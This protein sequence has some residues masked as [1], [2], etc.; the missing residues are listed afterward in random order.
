M[1]RHSRWAATLRRHTHYHI[2]VQTILLIQATIL[3]KTCWSGNMFT[4]VY[5]GYVH[6]QHIYYD[7][8]HNLYEDRENNMWISTSQY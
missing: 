4:S 3:T 2:Q 1:D 7:V 6:D 8:V 5:N